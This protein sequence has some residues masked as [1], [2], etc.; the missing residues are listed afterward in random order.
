MGTDYAGMS[1]YIP[2]QEDW[3]PELLCELQRAVPILESSTFDL[4]DP[5][6][7]GAFGGAFGASDGSPWRSPQSPA[8]VP[9]ATTGSPALSAAA[10]LGAA[11]A[12]RRVGTHSD[13]RGSNA[14]HSLG[15]GSWTSSQGSVGSTTAVNA[16]LLGSSGVRSTADPLSD[17]ALALPMSTLTSGRRR[18][19]PNRSTFQAHVCC[20]MDPLQVPRVL[21]TLQE[22]EPSKSARHWSRAFR[23]ISPFDGQLH[24]G[25]D[26]DGDTGAGEKMLGLL[27]R[28]GLEN[29]LL[30]VTRWESGCADRLGPELFR[31][32]S[33]Q[34]KELLRELQQAVRASFPPAE[35]LRREQRSSSGD[36]DLADLTEYLRCCGS[37]LGEEYAMSSQLGS[38]YGDR[39]LEAVDGLCPV[40][41]TAIGSTPPSE[42]I[43]AARGV[44]AGPPL[45]PRAARGAGG[46]RRLPREASPPSTKPFGLPGPKRAAAAVDAAMNTWDGFAAKACTLKERGMQP[47]LNKMSSTRSRLTAGSEDQVAT[48]ASPAVLGDEN[49]SVQNLVKLSDEDLVVLAKRLAADRAALSGTLRDLA[50]G[51]SGPS[52]E[53]SRRRAT[54]RR[55]PDEARLCQPLVGRVG[56]GTDRRGSRSLALRTAAAGSLSAR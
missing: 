36:S 56:A 21:E 35:L 22:A 41:I 13:V 44:C 15:I 8:G 46:S 55:A 6:A 37:D 45:H 20:V 24:E 47:Q 50:A 54:V 3:S 53:D 52:N 33:E 34:C 28:M 23:I 16:L 5:V 26:D 9:A 29:L 51:Y 30:V 25:F 31:C 49:L 14:M 17:D 27:S 11:A 12:G 43:W 1:L 2:P 48:A 40:D 38:D 19:Y 4:L 10:A 32:I 39:S 7:H 18:T 42:L